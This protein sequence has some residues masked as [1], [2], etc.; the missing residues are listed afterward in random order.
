MTTTTTTTKTFCPTAMTATFCGIDPEVLML[1]RLQ[2]LKQPNLI[3][4]KRHLKNQFEQEKSLLPILGR[5]NARRTPEERDEWWQLYIKHSKLD[6]KYRNL[7]SEAL[8]TYNHASILD[9]ISAEHTDAYGALV[10]ALDFA[11]YLLKNKINTKNILVN[12]YMRRDLPYQI[13][14]H[15]V[16][17]DYNPVGSN[18]GKAT[19]SDWSAS[20]NLA[21]TSEWD[22][23]GATKKLYGSSYEYTDRGYLF[24]DASAPWY[25]PRNLAVYIGRLEVLEAHVRE[26]L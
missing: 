20:P 8:W 14:C 18:L 23:S 15:L 17:R 13:T 4:V 16:N 3:S 6:D 10:Y 11:R 9:D 12:A 2:G 24:H 1:S 22:K 26:T 21:L 19:W 5:K 7:V 25:G